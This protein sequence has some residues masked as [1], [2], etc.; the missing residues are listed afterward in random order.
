MRLHVVY[1]LLHTLRRAPQRLAH[2]LVGLSL[3]PQIQQLGFFVLRPVFSRSRHWFFLLRS[4]EVIPRR[5][6]FRAAV[7]PWARPA[8]LFVQD[9]QAHRP[10]SV[11]PRGGPVVALFARAHSSTTYTPPYRRRSQQPHVSF[12]R[13]FPVCSTRLPSCLIR[14]A[15]GTHSSISCFIRRSPSIPPPCP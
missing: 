6:K 5:D 10:D 8:P 11:Q 3:A 15:H 7:P 14:S 2:L 9:V 12:P 4:P 1:V 13:T